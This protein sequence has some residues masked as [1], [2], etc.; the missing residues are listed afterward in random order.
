M[1]T[2]AV[3]SGGPSASAAT[4]DSSSG[5]T[6]YVD[7]LSSTCSDSGSGTQALPFCTLQAAA[8][9]AQPGDTLLVSTA[10]NTVIKQDVTF[11]QSGTPAQPITVAWSGTAPEWTG[12]GTGS[13]VLTFDHVHD[14]NV[15]GLA[16]SY[17]GEDGVDVADSQDITLN[18]MAFSQGSVGA[19]TAPVAVSIDDSSSSITVS[20]SRISQTDAP[21]TTDGIRVADATGVTLTTN[22]MTV[23]SSGTPISVS[24]STDVDVTSNTVFG[25]CA[26]AA[27][28]GTSSATLEN[29]EFGPESS[30]SCASGFSAVTVDAA[31]APAVHSDYNLFGPPSSGTDYTWAGTGYTDVP[32][33]NAATG[34][35][36]NDTMETSSGIP[37]GES[38]PVDSADCDAPGELDT[39]YLGKPHVDDPLVPNTGLGD[40]YADRGATEL[41]DTLPGVGFGISPEVNNLPAGAAPVTATVTMSLAAEKS[42]F[43]Y[44][45]SYM[46]NFG[47][48][49]AP[50]PAVAGGS[51][52]LASHDYQAPGVYT[53][54]VTATATDGTTDQINETPFYVLDSQP[55]Q[56]SLTATPDYGQPD[57]ASFTATVPGHNDLSSE[58][59][60]YGDGTPAESANASSSD[61]QDGWEHV[62]AEP[63]SYAATLTVKD[64][65]GRVTTAQATVVVGDQVKSVSITRILAQTVP[66]H[67]VV[68][69][70]LTEIT[71]NATITPNGSEVSADRG[72]FANI[73][74]TSPKD[75]G[76]VIM[77]PD[78]T[79][80]PDRAAVQFS[81]GR[82]AENLAL[83]TG[84]NTI[85]FYNSSSGP[86]SLEV[87]RQAEDAETNPAAENTGD[88]GAAYV[89]VTPV[90]VLNPRELAPDHDTVIPV[91]GQD[92]VPANASAVV[93]DV[94]SSHSA[95]AGHFVTWAENNR[96]H[97]QLTGSYWAKGQQVTDAVTVPV[98]G[99]VILDNDS[100]G[101][102][103]LSAQVVGYYTS[104]SSTSGVFLPATPARLTKVTLPGKHWVKLTVAGK[105]GIPATGITSAMLN[106]TAVDATASG[107]LIGYADGTSIPSGLTSLSYASGDGAAVSS[108]IVPVGKDGAIDVYNSGLRN[109]TIAVDLAGSYYAG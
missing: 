70:P 7:E 52:L 26:S 108:A 22:E 82:P 86:I 58:T 8:N 59:L 81:A 33:F 54:S 89:P 97:T 100:A 41:Q 80:R 51:S 103:Y 36:G 47:D 84:G 16:I 15:S 35:G 39:D 109:I 44:P 67:G 19:D 98:S 46:V 1:G 105:D 53:V 49:S 107:T 42:S 87:D 71:G 64:L 9:V 75:S 50:A 83:V 29:N 77:Y 18:Q 40:C 66:A 68:K 93:L 43:G 13:A 92:G 95:A 6:L 21:A 17:S 99:R 55:P 28:T 60:S 74:V 37:A 104:P 94:T 12:S 65:L 76:S 57:T 4:A 5:T 69:V 106:L 91:A 101:N 30:I 10:G 20:R 62:Y 48:G 56:E 2:A 96:S 90:S 3:L 25:T 32:T 34:Q 38:S 63:G 61:S 23:A 85:D 45:V 27:I 31:A 79:S 14:I 24:D 102:A 88:T 11:S 72:A 78:G 73:I